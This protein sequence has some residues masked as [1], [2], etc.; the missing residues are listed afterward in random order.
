MDK[1]KE[2]LCTLCDVSKAFDRVWHRGILYKLRR[3]GIKG[4]LLR[5]FEAYLRGRPQ[6]TVVN[7]QESEIEP[8]EAG[9]P[10]G[11]IIGPLLFILYMDDIIQAVNMEIRLY[12]D[13]A[14]LYTEYE[15]NKILWRRTYQKF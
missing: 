4:R 5:W 13:D 1:G 6:R 12:A 9:V 14:T 7:G 8:I 10:Q 2:V 15:G 11:S 3:A